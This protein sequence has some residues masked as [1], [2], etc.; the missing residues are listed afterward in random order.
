MIQIKGAVV[1][2]SGNTNKINVTYNTIDES[3]QITSS[4]RRAALIVK[5]EDADVKKAIA[6]LEKFINE[7]VEV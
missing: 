2:P 3:G 1:F 7:N 6:E 4:L 5:D